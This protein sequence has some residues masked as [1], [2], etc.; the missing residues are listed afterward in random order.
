MST[1]GRFALLCGLIKP[2]KKL[3]LVSSVFNCQKAQSATYSAYDNIFMHEIIFSHKLHNIKAHLEVIPLMKFE[4]N[5]IISAFECCL[6][7][8]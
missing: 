7:L 1:V 8:N 5:V 3:T 4:I 6:C 2:V